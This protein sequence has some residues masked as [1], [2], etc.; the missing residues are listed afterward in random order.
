MTVN[1]LVRS[2]T[3]GSVSGSVFNDLNH[4]GIRDAGEPGL[5][6]VAV[7]AAGVSTTTDANGNYVLANL[8]PGSYAGQ[9]SLP[10]GWARTAPPTAGT[11][12]TV[13]AGQTVAGPLFGDVQISTVTMNFA[14]LLTLIQHYGQPGRFASGDLNGDGTVNFSD[15]LLLIQNYGHPLSGGAAA[16]AAEQGSLYAGEP[17][18]AAAILAQPDTDPNRLRDRF[19]PR[20]REGTK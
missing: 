2:P 1:A 8:N 17:S 15:V 12:V 20:R 6:G 7:I 18:A 4:N 5:G 9:E 14:Y 3:L 19:L 13:A 11:G 16:G 10:S